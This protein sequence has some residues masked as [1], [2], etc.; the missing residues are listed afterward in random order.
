VDAI[1]QARADELHPV[2]GSRITDTISDCEAVGIY[3]RLTQGKRSP[4]EQH[5][6]FM[7]GRADLAT[8]NDLRRAVGQ[9]PITVE[10]NHEVTN[11]DW[12]DSM[13]CYGLA[14]DVDPS[15]D[16]TMAPFNPD[17]DEQDAKW[18]QVL[19]IAA[20]HQLAEGAKWTSVK[21]DYPHLYPE[22]LEADPTPEMKQTFKD[23]G[24]EAVWSE[25]DAV[26]PRP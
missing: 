6:L 18:K 24:L 3:L 7:Q 25:L 21:R 26:L 23:A 10:E 14:G 5:A 11:A 2:L 19:Q 17:W 9:A 1:S 8:V 4:N 20:S 13:H 12:L 15:E 22:E 16:G